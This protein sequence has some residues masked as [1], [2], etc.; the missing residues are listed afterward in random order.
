MPV[1]WGQ[2]LGTRSAQQTRYTGAVNQDFPCGLQEEGGGHRAIGAPG[3]TQDVPPQLPMGC[4]SRAGSQAGM[5]FGVSLHLGG[6]GDSCDMSP[7]SQPG[8]HPWHSHHLSSS[9]CQ[10]G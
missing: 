6:R 9:R 8:A 10:E 1:P 4:L 3:V 5:G 2:G 7:L